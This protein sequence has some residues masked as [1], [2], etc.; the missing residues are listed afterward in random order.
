MATR[1]REIGPWALVAMACAVIAGWLGLRDG[2]AF[3]DYDSE[4]QPAFH[5]LAHGDLSGFAAHVPS[6][7]GSLVMRAPF[8]LVAGLV[9][10]GDDGVFHAVS[11]P[12]LI[13][14]ALL[15]TGLAVTARRRGWSPWACLAVVVLVV[16]GPPAIA[17]L[18]Y[19]HAE[20]LMVAAL[21]VGAVLAA[22]RGHAWGAGL[23]LGL[24]V[25]G[26]PWALVVAA[27][28]LVAL[29]R[30]RWR[31]L[32][33]AG[34]TGAAILAP[35]AL[36]GHGFVDSG[37]MAATDTGTIFKPQQ[38]WWLAGHHA[39]LVGRPH[40]RIAPGWLSSAGRPL[41]VIVAAALSL[42]WAR[43][44]R[45]SDV[46]GLLTLV[47][48]LRCV[49]DPWNNLYYHAPFLAA[50]AAWEAHSARRA[51]WATIAAALA[52]RLSLVLVPGVASSDPQAVA[53]LVWALPATFVLGLAVFAPA[54]AA[55]LADRAGDLA[56][57]AFPSVAGRGARSSATA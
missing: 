52:L 11:A 14:L 48:L 10:S 44:N 39:H 8:A 51:P 24:A 57:R 22:R 3:T 32:V 21:A 17:A 53:Y 47:L 20:E 33:A 46:L 23:L 4:A 42:L 56:R 25:A 54:R 36:A 50:L 37:R 5:A 1:A 30:G 29:P 41:I 31:V 26:K 7:G 19:G 43:R 12:G 55:A 27:P 35:L 13:A 15:A 18:R 40:A 6:Y 28:V 16:A 49:L 9:G 45:R 2:W 34:V 38:I